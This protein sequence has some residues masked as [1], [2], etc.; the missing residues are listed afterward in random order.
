[1]TAKI[2]VA[3]DELNLL[4]VFK[5][6]LEELNYTAIICK[7]GEE[8]FEA[9]NNNPDTALIISDMR[10]PGFSGIELLEKVKKINP[11]IEF[12]IMTGFGSIEEAVKAIKL[13]A[14]DFITKP[15]Q[16]DKVI[17]SIENA[18]ER[19][20][21]KKEN[22]FLKEQLNNN[23]GFEGIIGI[24]F[25][26]QNI[27]KTIL[28]IRNVDGNVLIL[29]ESG[30]GKELIAK[31]VHKN[32]IYK[33]KPFIAI[34]CSTIPKDLFESE[35]FG[36]VK[37]SF[38]TA[39]SDKIGLF[40]TADKGIL[41]LDEI[42]EIPMSVQSKLLRAIQFGEIK[43][44]GSTKIEKVNVRIIAA[45]NRNIRSLIDLGE[46]RDDLYYRINIIEI[47]IPPLRKRKE[48]IPLLINHFVLKYSEKHKKDIAY[49]S[50]KVMNFF[51]LYEW[52]GN[53]RE[54]ENFIERAII[55]D[56]D[57]KIDTNDLPQT[58]IDFTENNSQ[59]KESLIFNISEKTLD[60]AEKEAI[61]IAL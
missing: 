35:L 9:F 37:G 33:E 17:I 30:T 11:D 40:K 5:R 36:H 44:V 8:A 47:T 48:D 19:R 21:L 53:I 39:V 25:K 31:S 24:D 46:F 50:E 23:L 6:F 45:S 16:I 41:F 29:G 59:F 12:L 4:E 52:P 38:T 55:M 1:M 56:S 7:T 54:L 60:I 51:L 10:M 34:N 13:G 58:F 14:F 20:K 26:M 32:S 28:K 2:I 43:K 3:D 15:F 57:N 49:I 22:F 18:L 42:T 27:F 61:L